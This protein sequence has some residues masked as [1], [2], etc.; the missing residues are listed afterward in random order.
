[1]TL[2]IN[3]GCARKKHDREHKLEDHGQFTS[4]LSGPDAQLYAIRNTLNARSP[5]LL[6]K[7]RPRPGQVTAEARFAHASADFAD[8][9]ARPGERYAVGGER[10]TRESGP[11]SGRGVTREILILEGT[12]L[13][14]CNCHP[15]LRSR[16]GPTLNALPQ[17]APTVGRAPWSPCWATVTTSGTPPAWRIAA[18]YMRACT[19]HVAPTPFCTQVTFLHTQAI[20]LHTQGVVGSRGA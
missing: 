18:R 14:G 20:V 10:E 11:A 8:H 9:V 1:M 4:D 16:C 17:G 7:S 5:T 19:L 3:R 2:G 13:P 15:A 12:D 6:A